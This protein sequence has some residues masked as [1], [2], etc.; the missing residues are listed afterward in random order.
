MFYGWLD[1]VGRRFTLLGLLWPS[2]KR[3]HS[4][5][6]PSGHRCD[7]HPN[8]ACFRVPLTSAMSQVRGAG[9]V[10]ATCRRRPSMH[11]RAWPWGATW[12]TW[13]TPRTTWSARSAN[14]QP[15][16]LELVVPNHWVESLL[17]DSLFAYGGPGRL[18]TYKL[19]LF[20]HFH[21]KNK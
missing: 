10:T 16:E 11:R 6:L 5:V 1:T 4:A 13:Q 9:G 7:C 18:L 2:T 3:L 15:P 14:Q 17:W 8:P 19:Y 20:M 12:C 21:Y